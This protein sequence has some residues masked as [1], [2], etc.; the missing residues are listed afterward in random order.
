M[1]FIAT[2]IKDLWIVESRVFEDERG[3]FLESY[4]RKTFAENGIKY[5]F[6][7][8]NFSRSSK[9]V[10]R[11]LHFQKEPHAQAKLVRVMNGSVYDVAVDLRPKSATFG[12]SFGLELSASNRKSLLIPPGF[13][14][15]FCALEDKTD[16][17]YK[18]SDF[19]APA[20]DAGLLWNDPDLN[21]KWPLAQP[22]VSPKDLK[23]PSFK[24][25]KE[26]MAA[27]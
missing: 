15:G 25:L 8:D 9:G 16:F 27:C 21:I 7:Q 3:F 2:P 22:K 19:Y 4:S 23:L 6:V 5:D 17:V 20:Y 18:C 26:Q 1:I 13:A 10:L 14:H 24:R 11:G 12:Q